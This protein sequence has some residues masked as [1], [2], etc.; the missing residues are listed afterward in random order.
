[1]ERVTQNLFRDERK[2]NGRGL[3]IGD[4]IVTSISIW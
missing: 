1:M 2:K 4:K 3:L